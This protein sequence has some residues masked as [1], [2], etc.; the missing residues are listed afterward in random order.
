MFYESDVIFNKSD[1]M[2]NESDISLNQSDVNVSTIQSQHGIVLVYS[3][4]TSIAIA[5][6]AGIM[7]LVTVVGNCLVLL[8]FVREPKLRKLSEFLVLNLALSDVL[9]GA[10]AIPL[11]VPYILTGQWLPELGGLPM[12][13]FWIC[14]DYIVTGVSTLNLCV[15]S[16]DRYLQ[17][18]APVW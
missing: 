16:L 10:V 11:Y 7:A 8:V 14:M 2:L 13:Y 1:I 6:L 9:V 4:P 12:C 15:I 5:V 17:V 18:A 3:L